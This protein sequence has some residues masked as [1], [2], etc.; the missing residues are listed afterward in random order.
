[1]PEFTHTTSETKARGPTST[2]LSKLLEMI[3]R[4][5]F[6][7][8]DAAAARHGWEVTVHRGGL[9]REYRDPRFHA[10][11]SCPLC[12]GSGEAGHEQCS[13]CDSTGRV[14]SAAVDG[15]G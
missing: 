14:T 2:G 4:H 7:A 15:R 6:A 1:M 11:H 3:G 13:Q 12:D 8:N 10:L 9:G 5:L